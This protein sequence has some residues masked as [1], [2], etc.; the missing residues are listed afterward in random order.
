M[1]SLS[2]SRLDEIR[3]YLERHGLTYELLQTEMLDHICCDIEQY[4][5]EGL[6]FEVALEKVKSEIPKN[7]FKQL[8]SE[9]MESIGQKTKLTVVLTYGSFSMLVLATAF[10]MMHFPGAGQLLI[11]S[12]AGLAITLISGVLSNPLIKEKGR[13]RVALFALTLSVILFLTSLC[14]QLLH[15][16]GGSFLRVVSVISSIAILSGYA[17]FC[18]SY[19]KKASR[20]LILRYVG[21]EAFSIEKTLII[22]FVFGASL[23]LWQNNFISVVFFIMLFSFGSIFYF[24]ST[25]QYYLDEQLKKTHRLSLLVVSVVAFA[26][27]ISPTMVDL[28]DVP[29]RVFLNWSTFILVSIAV[30]VYY[31]RFSDDKHQYILGLISLL[32][33]LLTSL[34]LLAKSGLL[35]ASDNEFVL[36]IVYSPVVYIGLFVAFGLFFKRPVFRALLLMTL[37]MYVFTYQLPGI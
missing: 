27:F 1:G 9:T 20:H 5:D 22:F 8:Q 25:W 29:T 18:Y 13:G 35:N 36:G 3:D 23:K 10:K 17:I 31:I 34:N 19:P 16:P 28:V 14:F 15:L 7:Q 2:S 26:M 21:N 12:F 24:I 37:G 32:I 4:M 6:E 30:A 11:A 33:T